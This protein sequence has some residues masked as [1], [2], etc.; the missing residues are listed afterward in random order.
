[1][2]LQSGGPAPYTTAAAATTAIE[3]FRDRGFGTPI[4][5]ETLTRAGVPESIA[6]RTFLSLKILGLVDDRGMATEQFEDLRAARGEDEYRTR[7]QEW[8]R[9]VYQDVLQYADPAEHSLTRIAEAFRTYE[10]A[11][12]RKAMAGLFLGLWK[13][14]GL[15][16]LAGSEEGAPVPRA[17][18]GTATPPKP[19]GRVSAKSTQERLDDLPPGLIGLLRQIPWSTGWTPERR[20]GFIN[21]FKAALDFSV[22][23]KVSDGYS[24]V[25]VDAEAKVQM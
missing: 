2:A 10:P 11:G 5:S 3:A 13:Y 19:K 17:R 7:L 15:P 1:M 6:R 8:I 22:P 16:V 24:A 23:I 20:E 12:Q 25:A 21:A 9:A 4:T 14:S 18:P